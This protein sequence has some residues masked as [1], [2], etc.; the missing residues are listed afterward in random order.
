MPEGFSS[1]LRFE[2]KLHQVE[3]GCGPPAA[4]LNA[5][6]RQLVRFVRLLP[7]RTFSGR[8]IEKI[9]NARPVNRL[10]GFVKTLAL[11]FVLN[12]LIITK[13]LLISVYR[14][15][16]GIRRFSLGDHRERADFSISLFKIQCVLFVVLYTVTVTVT[17]YTLALF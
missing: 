4:P 1:Q 15:K 13:L 6:S 12:E 9:V 17:V 16:T 11:I 10:K 5:L 2:R 7:L 8:I 14:D 3:R